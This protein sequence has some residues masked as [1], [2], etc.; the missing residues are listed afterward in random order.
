MASLWRG[1]ESN[2]QKGN[3]MDNFIFEIVKGDQHLYIV[4]GD[5]IKKPGPLG[6]LMPNY[7]LKL[8]PKPRNALRISGFKQAKGFLDSAIALSPKAFRKLARVEE[9]WDRPI[10]VNMRR[11]SESKG[12][13]DCVAAQRLYVFKEQA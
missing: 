2:P 6:P 12:L 1:L 8:D 10:A 3:L 7:T 5:P 4:Q 9:D 11:C 13:V